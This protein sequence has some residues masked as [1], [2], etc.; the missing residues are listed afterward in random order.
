LTKDGFWGLT[1]L[2]S[3]DRFLLRFGSRLIYVLGGAK[4]DRWVKRTLKKE[5][6]RRKKEKPPRGGE[7]DEE[8]VFYGTIAT[9]TRNEE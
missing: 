3:C 6:R 9:R 5:K 2:K 4:K 7:S 8:V 1:V